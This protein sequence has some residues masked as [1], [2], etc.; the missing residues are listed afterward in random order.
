[1]AAT[2]AVVGVPG[3]RGVEAALRACAVAGVTALP[4]ADRAEAAR[5]WRSAT[6]VLVNASAHAS[7]SGLP[8]RALVAVL[9]DAVAAEMD[10]WRLAV[11][12]GAETVFGSDHD[13][14][15]LVEWLALA[16][17]PGGPPAVVVGVA[18]ACGGAGASTLAAALALRRASASKVTLVDADP[19]G[20]GLDVLLGA[21]RVAG[22]RWPDLAA[23]KGVIAADALAGALVKVDGVSLLSWVAREVPALPV[24]AMDA[25]LS[26]AARGS[27]LVV[28]DLPR[29]VD[30][31]AEHAAARTDSVVL[32]V[33]ASVRAVAAAASAASRWSAA[34]AEVGLAVRHPGPAD[35]S[36]GAVADAVG[37]PLLGVFPTDARLANFCDRG[38]FARG[39]RRSAAAVAADAIA[40]R[41]CLARAAA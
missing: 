1:M 5:A 26:A 3:G 31:A 30:A 34:G 33:P 24:E 36:P 12:L 16:G 23:S 32:V 35:L 8:R 39:L 25:V 37:L 6:A 7:V 11:Q 2:V 18:G 20:G 14:R 22:T 28:V 19:A 40:S 13:P 38:R 41:V 29:G 15:R 4:V 21:E 10:A 17:E 9:D 27:D